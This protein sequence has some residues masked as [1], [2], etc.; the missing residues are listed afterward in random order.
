MRRF[1]IVLFLTTVGCEDPGGFHV[2]L[3]DG[4]DIYC[5]SVLH[6][7]CGVTLKYCNDGNEYA[8]L[9]DLVFLEE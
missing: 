5:R 8:C 2:E 9:T 4:R 7:R 6:E 1:L 3:R